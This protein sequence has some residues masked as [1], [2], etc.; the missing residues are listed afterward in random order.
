MDG[1]AQLTLHPDA[2]AGIP[3]G[4]AARLESAIG[5]IQVRVKHDPAQ[6]RDVALMAKGGHYSNGQCANVLIRARTT[7]GGEGGALYDERV[8]VVAV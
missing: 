4:A 8:R 6:R 2:A 3:D 1:L 5:S 7:D